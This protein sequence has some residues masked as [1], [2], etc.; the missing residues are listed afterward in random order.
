MLAEKIKSSKKYKFESN[1]M[2]NYTIFELKE[3]CDTYKIYYLSTMKKDDIINLI[4]NDER[5]IKFS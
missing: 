1:D 3:I 5:I 2:K 4:I